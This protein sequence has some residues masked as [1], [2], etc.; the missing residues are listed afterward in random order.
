[1]ERD[2]TKRREILKLIAART[3]EGQA[4]SFRTLARELGLSEESACEYLKRLWR[5]R[6]LKSLERPERFAFRLGPGESLRELRFKIHRRGLERLRWWEQEEEE[7][8]FFS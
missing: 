5:E 4:T 2:V 7:E 6:L 8:D 3:R 1:M